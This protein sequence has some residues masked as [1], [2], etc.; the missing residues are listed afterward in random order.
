MASMIHVSRSKAKLDLRNN[1]SIS[2]SLLHLRA[3]ARFVAR[4]GAALVK[5]STDVQRVL[6]QRSL[7]EISSRFSAP[8]AG[9]QLRDYNV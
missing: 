3:R 2:R 8:F 6:S 1:W 4:S 5:S 7:E 9:Y